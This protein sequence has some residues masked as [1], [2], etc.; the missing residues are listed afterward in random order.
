MYKECYL[1]ISNYRLTGRKGSAKHELDLD[2]VYGELKKNMENKDICRYEDVK[3]V[4][5]CVIF[6]T[7]NQNRAMWGNLCVWNWK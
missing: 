6:T 4:A 3:L 7:N 2:G 5:K 1:H